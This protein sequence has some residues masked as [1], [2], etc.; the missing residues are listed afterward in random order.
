M[1]DAP[2]TSWA[3]WAWQAYREG[4]LVEAD[5]AQAQIDAAH[6]QNLINAAQPMLAEANA[7]LTADNAR[8]RAAMQAAIDIGIIPKSS[9]LDGGANRHSAEI[10]VADQF[11]TALNTGKAD[12]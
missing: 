6:V 1:S 3:T 2:S 9:A 10:R 8:L 11:R 7:A 12:T 4:R 5:T